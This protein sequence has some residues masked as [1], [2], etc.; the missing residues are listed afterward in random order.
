L[1]IDLGAGRMVGEMALLEPE[2]RRSQSI[3]CIEPAVLLVVSYDEVIEPVFQNPEFGFQFMRLISNRLF[4]ER[5]QLRRELELR[6]R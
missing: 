5:D 2:S 3:Q 4:S 6:A 1:G